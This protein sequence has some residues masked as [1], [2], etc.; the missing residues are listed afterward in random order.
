MSI[1]IKYPTVDSLDSN[2]PFIVLNFKTY[3]EARG[4]NALRLA[5]I[6]EKVHKKTGI[7]II[8]CPQVLDLKTVASNVRIPVFAQHVDYNPEGKSTGSVVGEALLEANIHGSIINHSEKRIDPKELEKTIFRMKE[9]NL[10]SIVCV[11]NDTEAKKIYNLKP[12]KPDFIAIEPP[13]LIGTE[14]SVSTA[15]PEI[16]KKS[17]QNVRDM[18]MLVGAGVKENNDLKLA[19]VYGAKGALLSSHYVKS[20][21]P[22][23]FLMDLIKGIY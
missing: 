21:D 17:V 13:E 9:L 11:K 7:N 23:K 5:K 4:D 12:I 16:I 18:P 22:E 14:T 8:V 1:L 19:M 15:K 6:A 20:S 3:P 2:K 10:K